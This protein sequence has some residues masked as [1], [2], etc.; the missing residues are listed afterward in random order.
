[1]YEKRVS[2]ILQAGGGSFNVLS[3]FSAQGA[4]RPG[5]KEDPSIHG[6]SSFPGYSHCL[7]KQVSQGN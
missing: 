7:L 5:A 2:R 3:L 4:K 6:A 1:M